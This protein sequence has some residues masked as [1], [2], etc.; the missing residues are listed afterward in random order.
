MKDDASFSNMFGY[1]NYDLIKSYT[2]DSSN[3]VT[4]TDF[5]LSLSSSFNKNE[6]G[7]EID[8]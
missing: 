4:M 6:I 8:S 1:A 7:F 3:I 5:R 2:V